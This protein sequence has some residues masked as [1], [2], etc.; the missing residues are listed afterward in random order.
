MNIIGEIEPNTDIHGILLQKYYRWRGCSNQQISAYNKWIT[1][2]L[3]R[4]LAAIK[5]NLEDGLCYFVN[6]QIYR[7][8]EGTFGSEAN[9]SSISHSRPLYPNACRMSGR[10]Y[11][12]SLFADLRVE[13]KETGELIKTIPAIHLGN[14]P[15]MLGSS[16]CN[17]SD[18]TVEETLAQGEC[19]T[20]PFGYFVIRGMERIILQQES[21]RLFRANLAPVT[22][23][24]S[25]KL[26][27]ESRG[28]KGS[29]SFKDL[30][31][32][33]TMTCKTP[34][35]TSIVAL[36]MNNVI[37]SINLTV[38][39]L[40]KDNVIPIFVAF[41][42]ISTY[43]R[44]YSDDKTFSYT[45]EQM[46]QN[47]LRWVKGDSERKD[48]IKQ[49]LEPSLTERDLYDDEK[50]IIHIRNHRGWNKSPPPNY[51]EKIILDFTHD[52]FPHISSE[53]P[54]S[55]I[56]MLAMM[57]AKLM[58]Y[59]VGFR[60]KDD[61][62]SWSNKRL[63]NSGR[64]CENLFGKLYGHLIKEIRDNGNVTH[65]DQVKNEIGRKK[66]KI[67]TE[68]FQNSIGTN[69]WGMKGTHRVENLSDQLKRD[70]TVSSI[71]QV[72]R[73][74][75]QTSQRATNMSIRGVQPTQY[76]I[77]D[78][79]DT[80]EGAACGIVKNPTVTCWVSV[81][82]DDTPVR[83][84][85]QKIALDEW[86]EGA[87]NIVL[88]GSF[89][90]WTNGDVGKAEIIR[91][92][93]SG[94]IPLDTC[95]VL[96]ADILY[97]YTDASRPMRPLVVVDP[98]TSIP[99][100]SRFSIDEIAKMDIQ[101]L[102]TNG[103]I[104]Y[105][106]AY[107]QEFIRVAPDIHYLRKWK[108]GIESRKLQLSE[109]RNAIQNK[110]YILRNENGSDENYDEKSL[111]TM[112]FGLEKELK[113]ELELP[114]THVELDPQS[115]WGIAASTIPFSNYNQAPRISYQCAMAKQALGIYHS[116]PWSRFDA[117]IKTNCTPT[118]ALVETEA[119]SF[120]SLTTN[121]QGAMVIAAIMCYQ[122]FNQEDSFIL[123]KDSID[124]GLFRLVKTTV[125][126]A[127]IKGR[128]E[129]MKEVP[130]M[131]T[132]SEKD[133]RYHA[134]GNRE[135]IG[136]PRIGAVLKQGDCIVAKKRVSIIDGKEIN[137]SVFLG[138]GEGGQVE[139]VK[140]RKNAA[141]ENVIIVKLRLVRKP[142]VGDKFAYTYAQKGTI[143]KIVPGEEM[144]YVTS[145]PNAGMRPDIISNPHAIPSRMTM[146]LMREI[147]LG[148]YACVK[149]IRLNAS[150]FR[151]INLKEAQDFLESRGYSR[152]GKYKLKDGRNNEFIEN[153]IFIGPVYLQP[154]R[155][156]VDDKAQA[157]GQGPIKALTHQPVG[158]RSRGGGM[159]MG[160]MERDALISHG[161]TGLLNERF[162]EVSDVHQTIW[163]TGC[164]T[165]AVTDTVQDR[166]SCRVC[167]GNHN[168][169]VT[170]SIPYV[171]NIFM[172][173]L[174]GLHISYR[175]MIKSKAKGSE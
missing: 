130:G 173:Y 35:Q 105:I 126:R 81:E 137:T 12:S 139:E 150:A 19:N 64:A 60:E 87:C 136:A 96:D 88:N 141:D 20:D 148:H 76:G 65:S 94:E 42:I 36:R 97:I 46:Q 123:N 4:Q 131:P 101:T 59:V 13:N 32:V 72:I 91:A 78:P 41:D 155:H 106:D 6:P 135:V 85:L 99:A 16:L 112:A 120:L 18:L 109:I 83:T 170:I 116:V 51:R 119:H 103:C 23:R 93:R 167:R 100:I 3:P 50:W 61:R 38:Q 138:V 75:T 30:G 9:I 17:L 169:F 14:I 110:S 63:E 152:N 70:S 175:H 55:K 15:I 113:T 107:E 165:I 84:I 77:V 142:K 56:E 53:N 68:A 44:E 34:L 144:P 69:N 82:S 159:R 115:L 90:G 39:S 37:R 133:E 114:F 80:P 26:K 171:Y 74:K 27:D 2:N 174:T 58:E 121:P 47:V 140:M 168:E 67:I 118:R 8:T 111:K 95:I 71:S 73:I 134:I 154:L 164:G 98:I 33:C 147:F 127:I 31:M 158:G 132:G 52:L 79:A 10:S 49:A 40:G 145:G 161:A 151:E 1:D 7:P 89:F 86:K 129:N 160:E 163:C 45:R 5:L 172:W 62:D 146:G 125:H 66:N 21:L 54:I 28:T 122:G 124:S 143:G 102:F 57:A 156:H 104:E 128:S 22:K 153:E 11:S 48:K 149:G 108:E 157:S 29:D 25:S 24:L 166:I 117:N 92:R 43:I 162:K